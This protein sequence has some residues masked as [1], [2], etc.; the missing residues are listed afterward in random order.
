[1]LRK[2][3]RYYKATIEAM[4][5]TLDKNVEYIVTDDIREYLTQYQ[6]K[7]T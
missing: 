5:A 7:M 3:L 6:Q 4:L 1:M 2:S